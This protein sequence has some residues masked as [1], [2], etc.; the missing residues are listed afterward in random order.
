MRHHAAIGTIVDL[1][2]DA[3]PSDVPTYARR[4]ASFLDSPPTPR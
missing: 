3:F 4:S 2:D 1:P